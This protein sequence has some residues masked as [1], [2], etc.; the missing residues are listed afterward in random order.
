MKKVLIATNYGDI[1]VELYEDKAP[2]T[3][4]NF[5][6]YVTDGFYTDT[7]FHRTIKNFMIQG[8][9]FALLDKEAGRGIGGLPGYRQKEA[10]TPIQC[11]SKNGLSNDKYTIA[12]ARTS[13]PHS[14]TSQFF[15]NTKDN[16]FLNYPGEENGWGYAVFGKV[17]DGFK[18]VDT[19][20]EVET[21]RLGMHSDVPKTPVVIESIT[22]W[23]EKPLY[24]NKEVAGDMPRGEGE[25]VIG[26]NVRSKVEYGE[27][28]QEQSESSTPQ[29]V[30]PPN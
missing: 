27:P 25:K 7:V 30:P 16:L 6:K 1:A 17:V 20:N 26:K 4:A 24:D 9:G 2:L 28:E 5:L 3:V 14:A 8:G 13:D 21:T 11:E 23:P 18:V 15:I 12:M 19:I 22:L 10:S 29:V